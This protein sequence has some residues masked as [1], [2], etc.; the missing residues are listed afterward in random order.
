MSNWKDSP[1]NGRNH[2]DVNGAKQPIEHSASNYPD[3]IFGSLFKYVFRHDRKAGEEDLQKGLWYTEWLRRRYVYQDIEECAAGDFIA[4]HSE[5]DEHQKEIILL[6]E[7]LNESNL[8]VSNWEDNEK[9]INEIEY[10][11]K[12]MIEKYY[13]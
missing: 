6:L 8:D 4:S 10:H 12:Q 7:E 1:G 9:S 2:Y 3:F 13:G 11:I 5:L